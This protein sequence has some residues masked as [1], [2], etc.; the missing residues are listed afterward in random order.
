MLAALFIAKVMVVR[1]SLRWLSPTRRLMLRLNLKLLAAALSVGNLAL[2][3]AVAPLASAASLPLS[4]ASVVL[5]AVYLESAR[6]MLGR[7]LRWEAAATPLQ[8]REWLVPVGLLA[9][10]LA[11]TG[12]GGF[13]IWGLLYVLTEADIPAVSDLA[14]WLLGE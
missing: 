10:L 2:N 6:W 12:I 11:V 7:R 8:A 9:G 4:A 14:E 13:G 5:F 1:Q 3:V